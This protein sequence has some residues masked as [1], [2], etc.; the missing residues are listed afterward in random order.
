MGDVKV[1]D[2]VFDEQGQP[3]RVTFAT[4]IMENRDCYR[5]VF[6]EG[7]EIIADADHLWSVQFT[8][9]K[10][11]VERILTTREMVEDY[12]SGD[13]N[14]YAIPVASPLETKDQVLPIDPYCLGVWLADGHSYS[15]QITTHKDDVEIFKHFEEAGHKCL[16]RQ[17]NSETPN[18]I[19]V[20]IDK[21]E[22]APKFC[23]RGHD[24]KAM[25]RIN[26]RCRVCHNQRSNHKQNGSHIDPILPRKKR[27]SELLND[28]SLIKNK[29]IPAIYLRA[30]V[31]QRAALFQGIMDSDGYISDKGRCELT[32]SDKR[33]FDQ[34]FELAVSLG[35]KPSVKEK[36][37]VNAWRMGFTAYDDQGVFRLTRKRVL[38][39]SR[40]GRR[41]SETTRRRIVLIEKVPSVPVRCITVDSPSHL[42][43]AG[44][45]MIPTHNTECGN[46]WLG[47][48]MHFAPGPILAVQPTVDMAKRLSKQRIAPMID[49]TPALRG[50][51]SAPRARDASN[52]MLVKEFRGGFLIM[53]GSNSASALSSMPVRYL[54]LDEV[55]RYPTDVEEEGDPVLLAERRTNTFSRRKI[56][57][58]STPTVKGLSR[59]ESEFKASDQRFYFVPCP[60]C[61]HE[62]ALVW[63]GIKWDKDNSRNVWYECGECAGR[64]EEH[65]KTAMLAAGQWRAT[66]EAESH[67][68]VG[69]HLNAL[70]CPVGWRSWADIVGEFLDAKSN[71]E[72]LKT[73]VNT[74]L[75]ESFDDEY[76]SVLDSENLASR[77][78]FYEPMTAPEP[79]CLATAGVDVQDDRLAV[80]IR[81][82]G[83]GEQSWLIYH[84]EIYGDPA[85]SNVWI[86]LKSLLQSPIQHELGAT[87]TPR[88]VA[89]DSGGHHTQQVYAFCR[90]HKRTLGAVA[91]KGQS[92]AG[93]SPVG[94]PV[95]VDL[96][97]KG[98]AIKKG[99]ELYPVG[100]DTIKSTLYA[101]LKSAEGEG[102][103]HFYHGVGPEYFKQLTSERQIIRYRN[104]Y[105]KK[106]WTKKSTDRNEALDCEVYAYAALHILYMHVDRTQIWRVF[107]DRL[108]P[109]AGEGVAAPPSPV[110]SAPR[111]RTP[112]IHT[113]RNAFT[114]RVLGR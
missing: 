72:R 30:S 64:I 82:W 104:G 81:G 42:Y 49:E 40:E 76:T 87:L 38:L 17:L 57:L 58:T 94:R 83:A 88:I 34:C 93:K 13:R 51:V 99:A 33:L 10:K 112:A 108:Q 35:L 45:S 106:E 56:L 54:F 2:T 90:D 5:I 19:N 102:Q 77:C 89:I 114:D 65:H 47:Y 24:T 23:M 86:Q 111:P 84:T 6:S 80:V 37:K 46:N 25:G 62:Q 27:F 31:D 3:C 113:R 79:V 53:T 32:L 4:E 73:W 52:T 15:A 59:I 50:L 41:V 103:Y 61:G 22:L 101:R 8:E 110:S 78:E 60:H 16:I 68:T 75:A 85:L 11:E 29:H 67:K 18:T 36:P 98:Q 71:R 107:A 14:K 69:Y 74:V 48:I 44:K 55:D 7:S 66:A 9:K 91:I 1:G 39:P 95:K 92:Q 109:K 43:L 105:P 97:Y 63:A 21:K 20:M 100:S 28:L 26:G 12:K 96:N 70:Y